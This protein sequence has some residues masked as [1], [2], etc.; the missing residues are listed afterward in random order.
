MHPTAGP[1][2]LVAFALLTIVVEWFVSGHTI[3]MFITVYPK[4]NRSVEYIHFVL[5]LYLSM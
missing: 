1:T 2:L 5:C 4:L 3:Q